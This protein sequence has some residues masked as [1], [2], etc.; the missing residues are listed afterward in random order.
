MLGANLSYAFR[1]LVK[2]PAF[3]LT[4]VLSLALGIGA[5]AAIFSLVNGL[6]F[7]P[8]GTKN[9]EELVA[10]RVS[11]KKLNLDRISMSATD[12]ADIRDN[13]QVFSKAAMLNLEGLNYTGGDSPERLQAALVTWEWFGVF[14]TDPILGR[15]FHREED[16]PGAN[17]VAV[18][19]F[20]TWKRLFG[21]DRAI[22][23]R[24]IEF[25]K[26]PYRVV[27]VMPSDFAWP[28]E[29]DVWIPIGLPLKEY[30][31]DNRFNENILW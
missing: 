7:H 5:N 14:G 9:P 20:K 21:G 30:G 6:L 18:L 22:L 25:N 10:P 15:G 2:S 24:T 11:Y 23:G 1:T 12:F 16:Q 27:G 19:S 31:R 13:R 26:A 3:T 8:S 28:A 17:H 4:V 29:A